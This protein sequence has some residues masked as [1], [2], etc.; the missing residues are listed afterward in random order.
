MR[1]ECREGLDEEFEALLGDLAHLVR[2]DEPSCESYVVT[3]A[4]G[5]R[6]HFAIHARFADWLSFERHAETTH[7]R[8]LMPRLTA[9]MA[10]PMAMEIFL[11]A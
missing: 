4:M 8:R 5:S 2:A 11:E 10:G 3:R 7:L 1:I 9:L 6:S